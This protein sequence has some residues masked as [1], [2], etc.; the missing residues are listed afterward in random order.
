MHLS[1]YFFLQI[2]FH[3]T[4]HVLT[5]P[6]IFQNDQTLISIENRYE[7]L[8]LDKKSTH[9]LLQTSLSSSNSTISAIQ[10]SFPNLVAK[11]CP[12]KKLIL[13]FFPNHLNQ[14]C[15]NFLTIDAP[16]ETDLLCLDK[17]TNHQSQN[18][19]CIS[20]ADSKVI[21]GRNY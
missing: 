3:N 14:K 10:H 6:R 20:T 19:L 8:S 16:Y 1:F 2:L 21:V 13:E 17:T 18:L 7:T 12:Q 11:G 15:S 9:L 4:T 5:A